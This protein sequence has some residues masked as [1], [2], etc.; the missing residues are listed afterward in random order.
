MLKLVNQF[1]NPPDDYL[2][3][4]LHRGRIEGSIP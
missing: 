4:V 3:V 2:V 1:S